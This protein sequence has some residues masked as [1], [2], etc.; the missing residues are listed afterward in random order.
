MNASEVSIGLAHEMVIR[1][2]KVGAE[3]SDFTTLS[4][5]EDIGRQVLGLI[6]GT[7]EVVVKKSLMLV[8]SLVAIPVLKRTFFVSDCLKVDISDKAKV[9]ISYLGDNFQA[10]HLETKVIQR[11]GYQLS[12][13]LLSK[14][15]L[16]Q[17]IQA[18]LSPG[19]ETDM[20]AIFSL[21]KKQ[22]HGQPGILLTNGYSNIFYVRDCAGVLRAVRVDWDGDGWGVDANSVDGPYG[23]YE[24]YQVFSRNSGT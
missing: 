18:E 7:T 15:M 9:R 6:R 21:L 3:I 17:D 12:A 20:A 19:Y 10:W 2:V 22:G 11:K 13:R 14:R 1:L 16:D 4:K 5:S 8:N 23:W 24:G